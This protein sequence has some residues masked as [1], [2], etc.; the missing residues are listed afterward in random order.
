MT[1]YL[2]RIAAKFSYTL[3]VYMHREERD[4]VIVKP[5]RVPLP[6][7]VL[8]ILSPAGRDCGVC[9]WFVQRSPKGK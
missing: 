7:L 4:I 9:Q 5:F 1:S 6:R 8:E 3:G 2:D